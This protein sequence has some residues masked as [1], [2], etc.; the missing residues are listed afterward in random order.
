MRAFSAW[1]TSRRKGFQP[2]LA[3]AYWS[4]HIF[5]QISVAMEFGKQKTWQFGVVTAGFTEVIYFLHLA[6]TSLLCVE[7]LGR[8]GD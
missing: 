5:C 1:Q 6:Y 2:D 3:R 4:S 7:D 8:T